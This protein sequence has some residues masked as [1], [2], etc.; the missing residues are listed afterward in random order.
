MDTGISHWSSEKT[1]WAAGCGA[2]AGIEGF[3]ACPA[4]AFVAEP[5]AARAVVEGRAPVV[6]VAA[7]SD[8]RG[9]ARAFEASAA[10]RVVRGRFVVVV[11]LVVVAGAIEGLDVVLPGEARVAAPAVPGVL[12]TAVLLLS[13]PEVTDDRSGSA[14]D[15]AAD[16]DTSV[17][18]LAVV[19]GTARVGGLFRLEPTVLT[20]AV[21]LLD[22]FD[23]P[24][25]EGRALLDAAVGRRAPAVAAPAVVVVGRRGGIASLL[26]EPA[27]EAI[28]RRTE[29]VGVEGAGN[30]F[31]SGLPACAVLGAAS[32]SL[33]GV[34][35]SMTREAFQGWPAQIAAM[36]SR[37]SRAGA[38]RMEA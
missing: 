19:P 7:A 18:L 11:V 30:F 8:A 24:A 15:A 10:G 38:V 23:A 20:R 16:L 21:E 3:F 12:R 25:I 14:S 6:L 27:L 37:G 9:D 4:G 22:G 31:G 34:G 33:A 36:P 2:R 1:S 5:G 17:V 35:A 32:R 29:D 13:S 28:L 26:A